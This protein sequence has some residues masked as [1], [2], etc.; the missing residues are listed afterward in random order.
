VSTWP[1]SRSPARKPAAPARRARHD[2]D[3]TTPRD[4]IR[5]SSKQVRAATS[6]VAVTQTAA[7]FL[8]EPTEGDTAVTF[9][10]D[11]AYALGALHERER[12]ADAVAQL[13]D[14]WRGAG[15]RRREDVIAARIE[16]FTPREGSIAAWMAANL[17][18]QHLHDKLVAR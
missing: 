2:P 4:R 7:G 9:A 14:T 18:R 16:S 10:I 3:T 1:A 17:D 5:A 11:L 13:D 8:P 15:R 12:I 6:G